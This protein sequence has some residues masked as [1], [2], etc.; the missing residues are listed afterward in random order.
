MPL[1]NDEI[2]QLKN[3]CAKAYYQLH[4]DDILKKQSEKIM[5]EVCGIS[6]CKSSIR[7]HNKS[8]K[9]KYNII[10]KTVQ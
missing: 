1:S 8:T 7:A 4:K 5:C 3:K 9:H 6:F 2:K 10:V